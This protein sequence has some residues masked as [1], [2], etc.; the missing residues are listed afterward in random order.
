MKSPIE[1]S[2]GVRGHDFSLIVSA[3]LGLVSFSGLDTDELNDGWMD[4]Y[5]MQQ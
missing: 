2:D 4:G 5:A 1:G 3:W